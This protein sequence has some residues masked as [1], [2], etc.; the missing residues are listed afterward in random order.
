MKRHNVL[1]VL[2]LIVFVL[3]ACSPQVAP[4][5]G[6]PQETP[7]VSEPLP[8]TGDLPAGVEAARQALAD[9]LGI[10]VDDIAVVNY[11]QVDWPDGCLGLGGPAEA[12]L[13]AIT[14]GYAV[15]LEV[16]S[17]QYAYRTDLEGL[18]VREEAQEPVPAAVEAARQA[19]AERLGVSVEQIAVVDFQQ[20]DWPDGCLGLGG[21]AEL[22]LAAITPGYAVTL[23]ANGEQYAYRTNLEGTAV[24]ADMFDPTSAAADMARHAL[25]ERLGVTIDQVDLINMVPVEWPD[26]CLGLPAADELCA[27]VITPGFEITLQVEDQIYVFRTNEDGSSVREA[28]SGAPPAETMRDILAQRLGV[29]LSGV[30][31]VAEESVEWNNACLGVQLPDVMCAEV[32][33]PG[34]RLVYNIDGEEYVIHTNQDLSSYV[35]ASAP[36]PEADEAVIVWEERDGGCSTVLVDE[37]AVAYGPCEG[38]LMP[39]LFGTNDRIEELRYFIET[40]RSFEAET[41]AGVVTLRG[42]GEQEASEI[43]QRAVA[44]WSRIVFMEAREGQSDPDAVVVL[45]WQREGGIAGFCD[46]LQ[47]SAGGFAVGHSCKSDTRVG[48]FFLSPE[49]L[50]QVYAWRENLMPVELEQKDDAVADAMT[51]RLSFSGNG[52][53]TAS[54]QEQQ[55][56]LDL[57]NDLFNRITMNQ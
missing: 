16:N 35:V 12:C 24:R 33:T 53:Q 54:E 30:E 57:V 52:L 5:P 43:E 36:M 9:R 48:L 28:P 7:V 41:E 45:E 56:M 15:T 46:T 37:R 55:T 51:I 10:S 6:A 34:Y 22:C 8:P 31:P 13:A 44:E 42:E 49:E 29:S 40:F 25:A 27:M 21:P 18:A 4:Q 50:E 23:E 1:T 32:I 20:V 2:L 26:A 14:P 19:L 47:V 39:A 38:E 17:D 11:D 3:A